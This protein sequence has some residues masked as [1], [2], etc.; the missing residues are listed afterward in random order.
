MKIMIMKKADIL[1]YF[2]IA[3][4]LILYHAL[5]RFKLIYF[6]PV[7]YLGI[8]FLSSRY[9]SREKVK[10]DL[11]IGI[12]IL[13]YLLMVFLSMGAS[14]WNIKVEPALRDVLIFLSPLIL[15]LP[16]VRFK[17][18]HV[19]VLFIS[20]ILSYVAWVGLESF[21]LEF[22]FRILT[23]NYNS[24]SEFHNGIIF[25]G[26]FLVF[27]DRKKWLWALIALGVIFLTGKR[28][29]FLGLLPAIGVYYIFLVPTKL[30]LDKAFVGLTTWLY[31]LSFLLVGYFLL[32]VSQ[33]F[34]DQIDPNGSLTVNR[35]LM[36]REKFI[37]GL[38]REMESASVFIDLFGHGP[39]QADFYLME[40][41]RPDWVNKGKPVNPHNDSLKLIFDYGWIGSSLFFGV[42]YSFYIKSR[43]GILMFLYTIPL[44]LVDNSL[45][46]IYYLFIVGVIS[47]VDDPFTGK[48]ASELNYK[49]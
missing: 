7:I 45:I 10:L 34:I 46:F 6:L 21:N 48:L 11:N 43:A 19:K 12:G 2:L 40:H 8:V 16:H 15:F 36:G 42:L 29:I 13:L 44:F 17:M 33:W 39:G 47:R 30:N 5:D 35:F 32:E 3:P 49:I 18:V 23:S 38:R 31:F 20:S 41:V 25:G 22:S 27:L 24:N 37:F 26:F 9:S 14:F 4:G 28:A 1:V